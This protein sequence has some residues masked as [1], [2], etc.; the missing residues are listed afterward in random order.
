MQLRTTIPHD[1]EHDDR[2][3]DDRHQNHLD[4]DD[5]GLFYRWYVCA[6]SSSHCEV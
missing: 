4:D 6:L 3:N 5:D 2:E 1:H